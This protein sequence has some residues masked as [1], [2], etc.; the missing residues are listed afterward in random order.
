[1]DSVIVDERGRMPLISIIN[2]RENDFLLPVQEGSARP[3]NQSHSSK[4]SIKHCNYARSFK[5]WDGL[6]DCVHLSRTSEFPPA[7]LISLISGTLH[8][9][10]PE[11]LN[12]RMMYSSWAA[13]WVSAVVFKPRIVPRAHLCVQFSFISLKCLFESGNV[14][15]RLDS[16]S[17]ITSS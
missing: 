6:I 16:S 3:L 5:I 8:N 7:S 1:M 17:I 13:G 14:D 2:W 4:E 15:Q 9:H 10:E 12:C 11:L